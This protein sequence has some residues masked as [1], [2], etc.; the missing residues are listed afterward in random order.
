MVLSLPIRLSARYL[1]PILLLMAPASASAQ[2]K[3]GDAMIETYLAQETAKISER[4]LDGGED[5][6]GAVTTPDDLPHPVEASDL[7]PMHDRAAGKR[8]RKSHDL[9]EHSR[10]DRTRSKA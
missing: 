9:P 4:F 6:N 10:R 2:P 1:V 3:P 8:I 7:V 5:G